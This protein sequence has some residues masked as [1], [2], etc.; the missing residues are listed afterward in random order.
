MCNCWGRICLAAVVAVVMAGLAV[1]GMAQGHRIPVNDASIRI[2]KEVQ[3]SAEI[4]GILVYVNPTDE[5]QMVHKGDVVIRLKDD[6]IRAQH[7][8]ALKK[9]ESEV[10]IKFA[11]TALDKAEIDYQVQAEKNEK[12][13]KGFQV[14][15]ESE[16]RQARLEV[17]KAQAQL[18]KS[19]EDKIVLQLA[20]KTKET[21]LG[22]YTVQAPEDGVVTQ[23]HKWPGQAVRQG[24]P[25][26]TVTDLT[27][28]RAALHVDYSYREHISIGDQ[29]EILLGRRAAGTLEAP[30]ADTAA[31]PSAQ[32]GRNILEGA[33]GLRAAS[34]PGTP[35][36][37]APP[38]AVP[39]SPAA[40]FGDS[41]TGEKFIG[42]ITFISP[43][44]TAK[45][46][47]E[48]Y[49]NVPNRQD[50]E[51][52]YLLQQGVNVTAWIQGD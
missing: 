11:Q 6:V 48:V 3:L 12:A 29:V 21:E 8:E 26:L 43:K 13:P 36:A 33:P 52:R 1:P 9:A 46:E 5:G 44:L 45:G 50:A 37:A 15:T 31:A 10:E 25:V 38:A 2:L 49:V 30:P 34:P 32:S 18:E 28:L 40:A 23:V 19:N 7:A 16:M 41:P 20:A 4:P 51:G 24:D 17:Q 39:S 47:L 35:A 14:F 42:T 22:Q 27:I